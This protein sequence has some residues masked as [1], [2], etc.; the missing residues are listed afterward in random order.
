[1]HRLDIVFVGPVGNTHIAG[2]LHRAALAEGLASEAMDTS[3]AYAGP[4][5]VRALLWRAGGRRPVHLKAFSSNVVEMAAARRPRLLV[6]LGHAPLMA[7]DVRALRI[8]GI[9]CLNFST[10][11]PFNSAHHAPWHVESLKEHD[12]VFTPRRANI[13]ELGSLPCREVSYLPFAYDTALFARPSGT[14][15]SNESSHEGG[16]QA[17]GGTGGTVGCDTVLF[18]GGADADRAV[19][20]QQFNRAGIR[21]VLVGGYWERHRNVVADRRGTMSSGTISRMTAAAAVN[22]CLI[23]RANRDGHV[24]RSFEIPAVGGF[25][26][27]EA[28]AEHRALF[29]EEGRTV[30][31]FATPEEAAEKCRWALVH[32][33]ERQRM[34]AAAYVLVTGG[35][36]TYRHRLQEM[37]KIAAT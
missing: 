20:F 11:D 25:M 29:G 21:P 7:G 28:T 2:S 5:L 31:Y 1:M 27:A 6:T 24:M 34:A 4:R 23:R 19:F 26:L 22:L 35:G 14:F 18:V 16:M 15:R 37:L 10:D 33:A 12:V 9:R 36:N 17:G 13:E 3:P 8:L 30:L 32:S